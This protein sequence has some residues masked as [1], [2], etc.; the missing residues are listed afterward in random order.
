MTT[1]ASV[2]SGQLFMKTT[3][4][5]LI[6][7][8]LATFGL[9]VL[10]GLPSFAASHLL[11]VLAWVFEVTWIPALLSGAILFLILQMLRPRLNYFTEPFDFG[12]CFSLGAI[13]GAL[14]E[15]LSTGVYRTVSHRPFS[16]F[17]IAGAMLA[18]S[19]AGA[20]IVTA[21]LRN[22]AAIPRSKG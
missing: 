8:P 9:L 2:T 12:R 3:L 11:D 19:L 13:A 18:G 5:F 21:V 1:K 16:S 10:R 4:G 17:W 6:V 15:A 20:L 22:V 7:S 14:A